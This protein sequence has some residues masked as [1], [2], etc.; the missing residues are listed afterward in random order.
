[1]FQSIILVGLALLFARGTANALILGSLWIEVLVSVGLAGLVAM[2]LGLL[3][4][5][6]VSTADKATTAL[7]VLLLAMYLLSGGPADPHNF[8]G[9][10]ELSYLNSAKWGVSAVA[11]TIDMQKLN[12]C[13]GHRDPVL[14][15]FI[16][17]P[18]SERAEKNE[19]DDVCKSLWDHRAKTLG[20]SWL[21]LL[22][23]GAMALVGCASRLRSRER[24]H[25]AG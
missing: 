23:I 13:D 12:T 16:N 4:S 15:S 8:P 1:M 21:A 18:G 24:K 2:A 11:S 14:A 10:G 9:V 6:S 5:S 22:A 19:V 20:A 3:I 25:G 7:P 17:A